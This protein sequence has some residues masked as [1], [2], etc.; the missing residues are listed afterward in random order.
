MIRRSILCAG[1]LSFSLGLS[2][3]AQADFVAGKDAHAA[4]DY[5]TAFR[6]F[7]TSAKEGDAAS[8][9]YVGS[10]YSAGQG[11]PQ[12][13]AEG[14][15]WYQMAADQGF[16]A[17]QARLGRAYLYG[18]GVPKNEA[19]GLRFYRLAADQGNTYGQYGLGL[20]YVGGKGVKKDRKEA[21]R[22]YRLAADQG[23]APAQNDLGELY[24]DGK[25]VKK[26]REEAVRLFRLAADTGYPSAQTNMGKMYSKGRGVAK[27][28]VEAAR[29]Y[30]LGAE[31]GSTKA[32]C[33]LAYFLYNR[34]GIRSRTLSRGIFSKGKGYKYKVKGS[35]DN[36][37]ESYLWIIRAAQQG[38]KCGP[39]RWAANERNGWPGMLGVTTLF[40][41]ERF[42][43]RELGYEEAANLNNQADSGQVDAQFQLGMIHAGGE[44]VSRDREEI[45]FWRRQA[46]RYGIGQNL[47]IAHHWLNLAAAN[48]NPDAFDKLGRLCKRIRSQHRKG[49]D[50]DFGPPAG[51]GGLD[52]D[53]LAI[54]HFEAHPAAYPG[55]EIKPVF[56]NLCSVE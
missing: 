10:M 1:I 38:G 17:A 5:E 37:I 22:L 30:R 43:Q 42:V 13:D 25:G 41:A 51:Y 46:D 35:H 52:L 56:R 28:K 49:N 29:W 36:Q 19:E 54:E 16:A 39:M 21:A 15:R 47:K 50:D 31:N 6:E 3:P 32:K 20:A 11:V 2:A 7:L 33:D 23:Y 55:G 26:D 53:Y 34:G 45:A 9:D 12:S 8:Q 14:I 27:D 40:R 4:G 44:A 24:Y 18:A 48:G